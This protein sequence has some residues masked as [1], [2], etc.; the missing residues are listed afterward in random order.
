VDAE[1]AILISNVGKNDENND[2]DNR[3][4]ASEINWIAASVVRAMEGTEAVAEQ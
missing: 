3:R 2:D 4:V 1:V